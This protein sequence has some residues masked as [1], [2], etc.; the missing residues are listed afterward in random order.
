MYC[1]ITSAD[2]YVKNIFNLNY[3]LYSSYNVI[4]IETL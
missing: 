4:Y 1:Q 3:N 2:I